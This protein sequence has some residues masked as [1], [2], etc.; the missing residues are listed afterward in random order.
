MRALSRGRVAAIL[1]VCGAAAGGG[2]LVTAPRSAPPVVTAPDGTGIVSLPLRAVAPAAAP[3]TVGEPEEERERLPIRGT[4]GTAPGIQRTTKAPGAVT[5]AAM[6]VADASFDGIGEG[7]SGFAIHA[8]PPDPSIAVG[9]TQV[10][11][12]VNSSIAARAVREVP[13]RTL[14]SRSVRGAGP[15]SSAR[16]ATKFLSTMP[17]RLTAMTGG[18][19]SR[20]GRGWGGPRGASGGGRRQVVILGH[21]LATSGA[22]RRSLPV[23]WG[24]WGAGRAPRDARGR[25]GAAGRGDGEALRYCFFTSQRAAWSNRRPTT[26]S[27]RSQSSS[28]TGSTHVGSVWDAAVHAGVRSVIS[29]LWVVLQ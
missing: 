7:M 2:L 16:R 8:I 13:S 18:R 5:D 27:L 19:L 6:P 9:S 14:A 1:L 17:A 23:A 26:P 10:V 15:W 3:T 29:I 11:E 4:P 24:E 21:I 20:G 25:G 12:V 22:V 28:T